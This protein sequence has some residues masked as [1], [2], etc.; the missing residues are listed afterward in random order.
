[1]NTTKINVEIVKQSVNNNM[2]AVLNMVAAH[3]GGDVNITPA[4]IQGFILHRFL[5]YPYINKGLLCTFGKAKLSI[6]E[7]SGETD[8]LRLS[9]VEKNDDD[10]FE[11]IAEETNSI[12]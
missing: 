7:D 10:L 11:K 12:L 2:T 3:N 8:I 5:E 6:S 1:M 9:W 4:N